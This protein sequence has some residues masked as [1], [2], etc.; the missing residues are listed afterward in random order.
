MTGSAGSSRILGTLRA[1][2][3]TGIV[4]IE[5]RYDVALDEM[6]SAL[7]EPERLAR[8]YGRVEGDLRPGGEF[9]LHVESSG[10]EGTGRVDACEP[11]HRLLVTTRESDESFEEGQGTPPF[12]AHLEATL[13]GDGDQT[14]LV[15]EAR[16]MPVELLWAYGAG[17]QIHAETLA[18]YLAGREPGEADERWEE[19][20]AAYR[21][22]QV[23]VG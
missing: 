5:D 19:L 20:S 6:W 23:H 9:R 16:G 1:K 14:L 21:E 2:D 15:I 18:A 13:R 22:L 3:G 11:P 7:T 17:W 4:W 12:D 10:W 8:W